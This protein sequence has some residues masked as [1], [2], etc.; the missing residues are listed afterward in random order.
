MA[1]KMANAELHPVGQPIQ[2]AKTVA[3]IV[4][5]LQ[6]VGLFIGISFFAAAIV[7]YVK[8]KE[9]RG[10]WLESHFQWQLHTFWYGLLWATL[11]LLTRWIGIGYVILGLTSLWILYRIIKGWLRLNAGRTVG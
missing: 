8:R 2:S 9:V 11:G 3:T 7:N 4:Y 10:T 6:A 5:A 1:G